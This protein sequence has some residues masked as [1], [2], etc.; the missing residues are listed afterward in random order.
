MSG[1]AAPRHLAALC[2]GKVMRALFRVSGRR[3]SA[4][5][6]KYKPGSFGDDDITLGAVFHCDGERIVCYGFSSSFT[7]LAG[8][9]R[10]DA[11]PV[12]AYAELFEFSFSRSDHEELRRLLS[13]LDALCV[14]V[15][16]GQSAE[17]W[18][19]RQG[20]RP[21]RQGRGGGRTRPGRLA[22]RVK[23]KTFVLSRQRFSGTRLVQRRGA[24]RTR[25]A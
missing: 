4:T 17:A 23:G 19:K 15:E 5:V 21:V 9:R 24:A 18:C 8:K 7:D 10:G 2:G 13:A 20:L 11:G 6:S 12:V 1:A 3:W 25:R 14:S 22:I 16:Q